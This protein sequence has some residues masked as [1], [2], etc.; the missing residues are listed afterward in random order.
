M[1]FLWSEPKWAQKGTSYK[2][3]GKQSFQWK[4]GLSEV[5]RAGKKKGKR[6]MLGPQYPTEMM[7]VGHYRRSSAELGFAILL[8]TLPAWCSPASLPTGLT[9]A[10]GLGRCSLE[11]HTWR[12]A[13][14]GPPGLPCLPPRQPEPTLAGCS[15]HKHL[16]IRRLGKTQFLLGGPNSQ[17]LGI[18]CVTD[19]QAARIKPLSLD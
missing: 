16:P 13:Q 4:S 3:T 5:H 11:G 2:Q 19:S 7:R 6:D 17:E 10:G 9:A 1:P 18:V 8:P 14:Q 15:A 12:E